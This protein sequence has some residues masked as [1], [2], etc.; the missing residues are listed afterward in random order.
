[1]AL[2]LVLAVVALRRLAGWQHGE[3]K[4]VAG[5]IALWGIVAFAISLFRRPGDEQALLMLDRIGHWKDRFSS[6]FSFLREPEPGRGE[7]LHLERCE[8]LLPEALRK[9]PSDLPLPSLRWVWLAPLGALVLSLVPILRF[10]PNPG[11]LE[12]TPEMQDAAALQADELNREAAKVAEMDSLSEDEKKELEELR[13][14]VEDVAS[15]LADAEGLTAGEMLEALEARAKAAERLADKL[16]LAT[17]AWASEAMLNEMERHPDTDDLAFAL[18]DKNAESAAAEAFSLRDLLKSD[19]I[20]REIED[21]MTQSLEEIMGAATED[22]QSKPVGERF[23]NAERKM[24]DE[25]PKTAAREFEELAKH[26]Q[27]VDKREEAQEKLENL[28][29]KLRD[30]GSEIGGSQLQKMEQIAENEDGA[31]S[32]PSGEGLQSLDSDPLAND[33]QS[34]KAPQFSQ[35]PNQGGSESM[36][37]TP[38]NQQQGQSS[39][40]PGANQQPGD[41]SGQGGEQSLTAPVPGETPPQEGGNGQGVAQSDQSK[42]GQGQDGMLSAPVPGMNPGEAAPGSGMKMSGSA[43][44]MS[45]SGGNEAGSGTAEMVD[46][47]T[48]ALDAS[49]DA[50]VVAQI[51]QDGESTMKAIEGQARSESATRSRQEIVTDFLAAEEQALDEQSLPRSRRNHVIRYFSAIRKQFENT[52]G[53]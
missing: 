9:F 36:A 39:P 4:I 12:L 5:A 2:A 31:G 51:N 46:R 28:A 25:Q 23:G 52:E 14:Q 21:R 15:D 49:E 20:T 33:L 41:E 6:A 26:F 29:S 3:W 11:D 44:S 53:K 43:G 40:V 42:D 35:Q 22:D 19:E 13:T 10:P 30:A 16:G 47:Q 48:A 38:Q 1:M 34:M 32:G 18:R 45:G 7:R 50:R 37:S 17:D 24:L 8:K 27:M